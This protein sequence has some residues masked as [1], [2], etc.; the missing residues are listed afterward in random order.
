MFINGSLNPIS[1]IE[2]FKAVQS[3]A[4]SCYFCD[5]K[6]PRGVRLFE[7]QCCNRGASGIQGFSNRPG[8]SQAREV[9]ID[10]PTC[11]LNGLVYHNA[12]L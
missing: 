9:D 4:L 8:A 10:F 1:T 5:C 6:G 7:K 11:H 12:D 3:V 2:N